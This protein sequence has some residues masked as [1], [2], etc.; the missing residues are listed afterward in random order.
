MINNKEGVL[1]EYFGMNESDVWYTFK[2]IKCGGMMKTNL[3]YGKTV[4]LNELYRHMLSYVRELFGKDFTIYVKKNVNK[5]QRINLISIMKS[6][7]YKKYGVTIE[8]V[9]KE[10]KKSKFKHLVMED[11]YDDLIEVYGIESIDWM[12]LFNNL[13][14]FYCNN[15]NVIMY[16][17]NN[18][19]SNKIYA[20]FVK[21]L[22]LRVTGVIREI[23]TK[24]NTQWTKI[25]LEWNGGSRDIAIGSLIRNKREWYFNATRN[26]KLNRSDIRDF[27]KLINGRNEDDVLPEFCPVFPNV[28]MNYTTLDFSNKM[29]RQKGY[30]KMIDNNKKIWSFASLDRIDSNNGYTYDNVQI[31]CDFANSLK[32]SGNEN[33]IIRLGEFLKNNKNSMQFECGLGI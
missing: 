30:S 12:N 6:I 4:K 19:I 24:Y 27:D 1:D 25:R 9:R 21:N 16:I 33:Q 14:L 29:T 31:I 5:R 13:P 15:D 3:L 7:T 28:S 20:Y 32:G 2:G 8:K 26:K 17:A 10:L 22:G 11:I 23:R 18:I